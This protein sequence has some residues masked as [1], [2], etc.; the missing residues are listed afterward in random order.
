MASRIIVGVKYCFRY[1]QRNRQVRNGGDG[2]PI[3]MG[4]MPRAHRRRR[5]K[6][7]MSIED[8]NERF[9]LTK[10]MTWRSSRAKEGLPTAG[11]IATTAPSR[12]ASVRDAEGVM[13]VVEDSATSASDT[14]VRPVSRNGSTAQ[15]DP[16]AKQG[17]PEIFDIKSDVESRSRKS[18]S[19]DRPETAKS[20]ASHIAP[21]AKADTA[22]GDDE[23]EDQIQIAVPAELLPTPG[24]TCA[25]C[26]DTIEDDDDVRG[27]T[28]G[29]AFHA[30]CVDPWL[31]SR[32]ACCPLCKADYFVPKPRPDGPELEGTRRTRG[33]DVPSPPQHAF[34]GHGRGVHSFGGRRPTMVLPGRFMTIVYNEN[35][36]YGF[37]QVVRQPRP[38]R[39]RGRFGRSR[40]VA[41]TEGSSAHITSG[42]T[43]G[44]GSE[45]RGWR[46]RI[47]SIRLPS[48]SQPISSM[49][50]LWELGRRRNTV[51][52]DPSA[53]DIS[54]GRLEAG[55][56]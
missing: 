4:A 56:S 51:A 36:R 37:P 39:E 16:P 55:R 54:P 42:A 25:I 22:E 35:D 30:S 7:L 9:P 41:A 44:D 24:D 10:Y 33:D 3:D 26:I 52:N 34:M 29:H 49:P 19:E 6:K 1:N 5:E 20:A 17:I 23:D 40:S 21:I 2:E 32:R 8:V 50:S 31:T 14:H 13:K 45:G 38:L 12:P 18:E 11:G 48:A 27:L 43:E 53:A 15:N 28:C 46:E 47:R